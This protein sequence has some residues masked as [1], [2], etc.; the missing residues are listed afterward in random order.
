M[1]SLLIGWAMEPSSIAAVL[2]YQVQQLGA[3]RSRRGPGRRRK[4]EQGEGGD[5]K[6]LFHRAENRR[7]G[8]RSIDRDQP[9]PPRRRYRASQDERG[10]NRATG[11]RRSRQP[12]DLL[13]LRALL[14]RPAREGKRVVRLKGGDPSLFGRAGEEIAALVER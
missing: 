9:I 10:G 2:A 14:V 5:R 6:A 1:R 8:G 4:G 12:R 7:T 13:T 3:P 11:G